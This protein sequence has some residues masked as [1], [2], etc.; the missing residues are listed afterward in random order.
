MLR[1]TGNQNKLGTPQNIDQDAEG[2]QEKQHH[3]RGENENTPVQAGP[4]ESL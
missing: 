3:A 1:D 4:P 2:N